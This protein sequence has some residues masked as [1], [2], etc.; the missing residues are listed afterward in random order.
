MATKTAR[1][2]AA[3]APTASFTFDANTLV[4]R[5]LSAVPERSQDVLVRRFGLGASTKR[6]TLESI[7]ER[8]SITRERVRQIEAAGLEELRGSKRFKEE[9]GAFEEIATF[10]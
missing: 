10:I 7:G 2:T 6:E 1:K 8:S 9:Q 4:K 3:K 5:L